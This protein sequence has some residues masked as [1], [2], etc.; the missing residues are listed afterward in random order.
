[1]LLRRKRL[2][3][4]L[5]GTAFGVM[6]LGIVYLGLVVLACAGVIPAPTISANSLALSPLGVLPESV[7]NRMRTPP[8]SARA[9]LLSEAAGAK[10]GMIL[11]ISE[12][13]GMQPGPQPMYRM[14]DAAA[15]PVA[16]GEVGVTA[17]V[18][19][20]FQIAP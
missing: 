18:T 8:F 2:W 6:L 19:I 1:M 13:G 9:K 4:V 10:L 12:D 5:L 17:S 7:P 11:S 3:Q 16:A 14:A 20:V 15:V